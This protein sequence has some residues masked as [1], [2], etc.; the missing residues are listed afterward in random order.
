LRIDDRKE[1]AFQ[2]IC[3]GPAGPGGQLQHASLSARFEDL[4]CISLSSP[5][6]STH[7]GRSIVS[8]SIADEEAASSRLASAGTGSIDSRSSVS[9]LAAIMFI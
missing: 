3:A 7:P 1:E 8:L 9:V 5:A 6:K 4:E 2:R